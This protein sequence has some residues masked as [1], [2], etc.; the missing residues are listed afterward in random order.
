MPL[1]Q[2]KNWVI[3]PPAPQALFD[4]I[5]EHPLLVQV[6]YNRGVATPEA[7]RAFLTHDDAVQDN[8]YRLKDMTEAVARLVRAI[9]RG[10][11]ICV[12][13][14]FDADGVT[15]L[16]HACCQSR[17]DI[18][19]FLISSGANPSLVDQDGVGPLL[20]ACE[21]GLVDVARQL[22]EK[23]ANVSQADKTGDTP[24]HVACVTRLISTAV[25]L[26]QHG[27]PADAVNAKGQSPINLCKG[28]G[29]PLAEVLAAM[30]ARARER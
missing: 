17:A 8:P 22:I 7:V 9:E 11:T 1:R 12:Y 15:A 4:Q 10:E 30:N 5:P 25:L 16:S 28:A 24:L 21:R 19:S 3:Q 18:A 26:V 14:D 27:A 13:G 6:L 20:F 23:G 2:A 29:A